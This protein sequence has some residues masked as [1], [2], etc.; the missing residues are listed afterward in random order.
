[1]TSLK[2][3]AQELLD[4]REAYAAVSAQHPHA[5]E[6]SVRGVLWAPG[7]RLT[8]ARA[9]YFDAVRDPQVVLDALAEVIVAVAE[10]D[11]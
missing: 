8:R 9:D 4:A 5:S 2:D 1:M 3:L 11:S 10:G 7:E 6:T